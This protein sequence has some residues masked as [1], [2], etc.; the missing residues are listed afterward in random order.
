MALYPQSPQTR[1]L[2]LR[3][4]EIE[5]A[6]AKTAA[7]G[8][9]LQASQ[10]AKIAGIRSKLANHADGYF[11]IYAEET[12]APPRGGGMY[13]YHYQYEVLAGLEAAVSYV[14]GLPDKWSWRLVQRFPL[15]TGGRDEAYDLW[16]KLLKEK[17]YGKQS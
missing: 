2:S 5:R 13:F 15:T 8:K 1:P 9:Q 12:V 14:D 7:S 16:K 6:E 17:R 3:L 4:Q 10:T 11:V